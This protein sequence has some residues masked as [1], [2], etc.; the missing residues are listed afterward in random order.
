MPSIVDAVEF[1]REQYGLTQSQW[2]YVLR[3]QPSH[4][5][6]F[7][8][9]KR[10]LSKRS[11]GYAFAYGVP[12]EALFQTLPCFG[13]SDIDRRLASLRKQATPKAHP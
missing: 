10:A 2:A 3:M 6:E 5:S 1:R 7:V 13:S 4:Y 8:A 9:S 11:M 12:A